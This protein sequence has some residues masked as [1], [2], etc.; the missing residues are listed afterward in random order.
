MDLTNQEHPARTLKRGKQTI[1]VP[2]GKRLKIRVAPDGDMV[3]NE[4]VPI[5]RKWS[6]DLSISII[7]SDT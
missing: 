6:V 5:G 1:N 3:L 4:T 7:E 2:S